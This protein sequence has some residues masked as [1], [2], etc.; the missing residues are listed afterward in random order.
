LGEVSILSDSF[1]HR[2]DAEP[3]LVREQYSLS[4]M[5][6]AALGITLVAASG[7]TGETD[8]PSASPFVT[9]VGGTQLKFMAGGN[10]KETAWPGSGSGAALSLDIPD[11]QSGVVTSSNKRAVSDVALAASPASPYWVYY[12]GEWKRYGG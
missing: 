11:W 6:G 5:M 7:D 3:T 9:G 2:E 8:M 10:I 4:A 12:L 1:A